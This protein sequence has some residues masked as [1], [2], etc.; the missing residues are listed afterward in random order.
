[1]L[2]EAQIKRIANEV[3]TKTLGNAGYDRSEIDARPDY[4][5]EDALYVTVVFKNGAPATSGKDSAGAM[6]AL[7][8]ELRARGEMRFPHLIFD[9]PDDDRPYETEMRGTET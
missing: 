9:Y 1:M 2:N 7:V 4:D 5:D 6:E 3:L 8:D